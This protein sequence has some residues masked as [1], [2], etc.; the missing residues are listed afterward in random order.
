VDAALDEANQQVLVQ[1]LSH[2]ARGTLPGSS[3]SGS[4]CGTSSNRTGGG[5]RDAVVACAPPP[6]HMRGVQLLC[7]SHQPA[8][9]AGCAGL[10]Q[11]SC[12][13]VG[14]GVGVGVGGGV[15][16]GE[17]CI[18]VLAGQRW[19]QG[20]LS[21]GMLKGDACL[22]P[23]SASTKWRWRECTATHKSRS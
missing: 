17:G 10:V 19:A 9:H 11:V 4:A 3:S 6:P 23:V 20:Y 5:A 16:R 13:H 18:K 15:R 8:F 22:Y 1:L 21:R 12:P 2:M 14:V 7:V